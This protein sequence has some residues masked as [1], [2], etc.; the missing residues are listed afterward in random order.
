[1]SAVAESSRLRRLLWV[2]CGAALV[3][4][5]A[6]LAVG[7]LVAPLLGV[8]RGVMI[9]MGVVNL[10]YGAFSSSL[11][12]SDAPS[13]R[14]VSFL[15]RANLAWVVVCFALAVHFARPG[16]WLGAAYALV[17]GIFVGALALAERR[18]GLDDRRGAEH[19]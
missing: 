3:V 9:F 2:D 5:A 4:G 13:P 12:R 18:A 8:P 10:G 19:A 16:S 14:A 7:G 17:E 15:V 6:V 1:M 11:A